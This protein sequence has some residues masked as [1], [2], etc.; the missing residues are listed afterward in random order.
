MPPSRREKLIA[1]PGGD[2][3]LRRDAVPQVRRATDHVASRSSSPWRP[4][5][6]ACVAAVLPAGPPPMMTNRTVTAVRLRHLA[7]ASTGSLGDRH[8]AIVTRRSDR[9]RRRAWPAGSA[10]RRVVRSTSDTAFG[11]NRDGYAYWSR[12]SPTHSKCMP[13]GVRKLPPHANPCLRKIRTVR[14]SC[15]AGRSPGTTRSCSCRP[16]GPSCGA[17]G[18]RRSRAS[19]G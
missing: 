12:G 2:H 1:P 19:A 16:P 5:R 3:R 9:H 4:R 8:S 6:A 11:Q 15:P 17:T 7:R 14:S 10:R 18:T 13:S